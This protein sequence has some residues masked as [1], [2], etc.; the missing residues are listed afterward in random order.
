MDSCLLGRL[1]TESGRAER[2]AL[3]A[4]AW[5][6]GRISEQVLAK[7]LS[8]VW[9]LAEHPDATLPHPVWCRLFNAAGY[10]VDGV[11]T[12]RPTE[13]AALWLGSV[14]ERRTDWSWTPNPQVAA[15]Y[16][17]GGVGGRPRG[18]L[19]QVTAPPE[20]LLA[21]QRRLK[22]DPLAAPES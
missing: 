1:L 8:A 18:Q 10:T 4:R 5:T 22:S 3:L 6:T 16:A 14:F 20:A 12:A 13:G 11:R 7:H 21:C 9:S 19:W 2:P 17:V 15:R